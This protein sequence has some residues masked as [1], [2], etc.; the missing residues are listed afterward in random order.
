MAVPASAGAEQTHIPESENASRPATPREGETREY[1][2]E[3]WDI[4][5]AERDARWAR[6]QEGLNATAAAEAARDPFQANDPWQGGPPA[7][8]QAFGSSQSPGAGQNQ[9]PYTG[10]QYTQRSTYDIKLPYGINFPAYSG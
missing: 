2:T 6:W 3:E 7:Y 10:G 4:W 9:T 8:T 5:N 1:T